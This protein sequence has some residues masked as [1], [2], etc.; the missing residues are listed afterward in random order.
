MFAVPQEGDAVGNLKNLIEPVADVNDPDTLR[1]QFVDHP[2]Q[3]LG[4]AGGEGGAGFIHHDDAGILRECLGDLDDLLLG[5]GEAVALGIDRHLHADPL[6]QC[7]R[8]CLLAGAGNEADAAG[9]LSEENI[10][11]GGQVRDEVELLIND[12]DAGRLRSLRGGDGGRLA[13]DLDRALVRL[14]GAAENLDERA[15]AGAI[16]A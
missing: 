5:D 9:F 4:F 13:I 7:L 8:P 15:F 2:E 6:E 11:A 16:F 12:P 1:F 10:L 14:M 3:S